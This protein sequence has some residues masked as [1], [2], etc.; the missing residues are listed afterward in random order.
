MT[1]KNW[2]EESPHEFVLID[3]NNVVFPTYNLSLT[4]DEAASEAA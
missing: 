2:W 1:E 3:A 4:F